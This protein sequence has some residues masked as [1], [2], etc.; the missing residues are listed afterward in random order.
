[1]HILCIIWAILTHLLV[2]LHLIS[3]KLMFTSLEYPQTIF[4]HIF[5]TVFAI[6][7]TDILMGMEVDLLRTQEGHSCIKILTAAVSGHPTTSIYLSSHDPHAALQHLD[8][9]WSI[10]SQICASLRFALLLCIY[11]IRN[12]AIRDLGESIIFCYL[13]QKWAWKPG[14]A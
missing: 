12:N 9:T 14:C 13:M 8:M 10:A 3:A 2:Q 6:L 11:A 5:S 1:M 7:S 4:H